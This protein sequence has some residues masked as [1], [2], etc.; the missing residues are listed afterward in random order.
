LALVLLPLLFLGLV[1]CVLRLAGAGYPT[2]FFITRDGNTVESNDRFAWRFM[3]RQLARDPLPLAMSRQ[4]PTNTVRVF[5]LGESAAQG[6]PDPA[7]GFGR[8][9]EVM[10]KARHPGKNFEVINAAMTAINSH[11]VREIALECLRYEPDLFL[12]YCGN[13]EVVGPFGPGTVFQSGTPPMWFIRLQ[14]RLLRWRTCQELQRLAAPL[15]ESRTR[16]KQW[17]GMEIFLE[18]RVASDDPRLERVYEHFSRN[19]QDLIRAAGRRAVPVVIC[20]VPVNLEACSPFASEHRRGLTQAE[21]RSWRELYTLGTN[22]EEH[23][24][25]AAAEKRYAEAAALDARFAEVDFRRARCLAALG[26]PAES[27]NAFSDARDHD[28]LRFRADS[29]LNALVRELARHGGPRVRLYDADPEFERGQDELFH[30]HVHLTF[31]GNYRLASGFLPHVEA[32][33]SLGEGATATGKPVLTEDEC[34][35]SLAYTRWSR[36]GGDKTIMDRMRRPPFTLQFD[37]QTTFPQRL[38]RFREQGVVAGSPAEKK[39]SI[40]AYDRAL[41]D[42]PGDMLLRGTYVELLN[43]SGQYEKALREARTMLSQAPESARARQRIGHV[44]LYQGRFDE[45][46]QIYREALRTR[47]EMPETHSSI[48]SA[49]YGMGRDD[50]AMAAYR[51]AVARGCDTSE[52]HNNVS[53]VLLRRGDLDGAEEHLRRALQWTDEPMWRKN[54]GVVLYTRRKYGEA[55]AEFRAAVASLPNDAE[56]RNE[57]GLAWFAAGNTNEAITEFREAL[58]ISPDYEEA[59][60]N[61]EVAQAPRPGN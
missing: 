44:L 3:S 11:A 6:F 42:Q 60:R 24:D 17:R 35:S 26:R 20:T 12:V 27:R 25:W 61:L 32:A 31:S 28:A 53:A 1:E 2:A 22:A 41:K 48:V 33:L 18:R 23:A 47:P 4:K 52:L 46:I 21:E 30:E 45:A 10:L 58:R 36:W 56:L 39:R 5:I 34:A 9:L 59:R 7:F 16:P 50:E 40:E 51:T 15:L 13:N 29:R 37:R 8:I 43:Q 19:M 49:Y 14:L 57:L 38:A 54:L 55:A